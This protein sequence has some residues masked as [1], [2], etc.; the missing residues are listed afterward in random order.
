MIGDDDFL[1]RGF[2]LVEGR[3]DDKHSQ[4][5]EGWKFYMTDIFKMV[6][7]IPESKHGT[8]FRLTE[9]IWHIPFIRFTSD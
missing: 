9:K 2:T 6:K 1:R 4:K 3:K 7:S 5:F 8:D